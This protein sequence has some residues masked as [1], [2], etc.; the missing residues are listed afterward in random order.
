M[1]LA[2]PPVAVQRALFAALGPLARLRGY[3]A[4]NHRFSAD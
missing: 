3:R 2:G 1:Y 4:S